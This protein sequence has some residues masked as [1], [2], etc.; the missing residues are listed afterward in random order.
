MNA[1]SISV[2]AVQ[3]D[4]GTVVDDALAQA[5]ASEELVR[6]HAYSGTPK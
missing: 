2:A 6:F 1:G 4:V 3:V 5:D